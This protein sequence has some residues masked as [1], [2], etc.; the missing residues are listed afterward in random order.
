VGSLDISVSSV[1]EFVP[2][3]GV[4]DKSFLEDTQ[5]H[6]SQSSHRTTEQHDSDR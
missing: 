1:E 6:S 3:G 4:L 5:Q 2:D